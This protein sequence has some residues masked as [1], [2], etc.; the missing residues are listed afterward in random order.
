MKHCG[1]FCV[2][3]WPW[4]LIGIPLLLM[5]PLL[6]L[7][8]RYIE[9]DVAYN[10]QSDLQS[11]QMNWAAIETRNRGRHVLISG[12]PP[13]QAAIELTIAKAE[14]SLGVDKVTLTADV[15]APL[16]F[17]RLDAQV[18]NNKIQ[19]SGTLASQAEANKLQ[20]YADSLFGLDNVN[21][22]ITVNANTRPLRN[23]K[24]LLGVLANNAKISNSLGINVENDSLTLFGEAESLDAKLAIENELGQIKF[25]QA[26]NGQ[27]ISKMTVAPPPKVSCGDLVNNLLDQEQINF[28]SG[29][30]TI[31][32]QSYNLLNGIKSIIDSCP[33]ASFMIGGHTDSVG[34]ESFNVSLSLKRAQA[35]VDHLVNLGINKQQLTA[36]GYGSSKPI[37]DNASAF[38][39]AQNRRIEF[40]LKN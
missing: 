30:S 7:K 36:Q 32:T 13:S 3:W 34:N 24:E 39:R 25:R 11:I 21:S 23:T 9:A 26:L 10:T 4:V 29:K 19:L 5:L 31:S 8:W 27:A 16:E 15:K 17:P 22:N 28:E 1:L 18:I 35:V 40:T 6:A 37:A 33:N 12:T 2:R 20:K 38:G 14:K